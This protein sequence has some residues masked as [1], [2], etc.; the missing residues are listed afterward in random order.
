MAKEK[1]II[2]LEV[3]STKAVKGLKE[4][5]K[6]MEGVGKS[7]TAVSKGFKGVAVSMKAMGWGILVGLLAMV[8]EAFKRNQ[9]VSDLVARGMDALQKVVNV[10]VKVFQGALIVADALTF[11]LLNLSGA[12]DQ[13]S[14]SLQNQ[15]NEV[16][17]LQAQEQLIQLEFQKSAEV[18]RQ[19]RDDESKSI[20][21]RKSANQELGKILDEQH[22]VEMKNANRALEVSKNELAANSNSIELQE[23]VI[24]AKTKVAEVDERIT[25][26]RSEMLVNVNSLNRANQELS[27]TTGGVSTSVKEA[28]KSYEDLNKEMKTALGLD[29]TVESITKRIADA[30]KV[31]KEEIEKETEELEELIDSEKKYRNSS[32]KT[33]EELKDKEK[34]L[35]DE[36][37]SNIFSFYEYDFNLSAKENE[38]KLEERHQKRMRA[39]D[40]LDLLREQIKEEEKRL[41]SS[42][43]S[44]KIRVTKHNEEL[45]KKV[46]EH[47][48]KMI[49]SEIEFN[50]KIK[51]ARQMAR[52]E[53]SYLM[54]TDQDRELTDLK[55]EKD[56][57]MLMLEDD[58]ASQLK[59]QYWYAQEVLNIKQ[60]FRI[61]EVKLAEEEAQEL[62]DIETQRIEKAFSIASSFAAS[63][64]KFAGDNVKAQKSAAMLGITIDTAAAVSS[65]IRNAIPQGGG[66]PVLTP[67]IIA[68][69]LAIVFGG[70]AQ[71]KG[72]L[73]TVPGGSD[74]GTPDLQGLQAGIGVGDVPRLPGDNNIDMD[75]PPVQA[76]V[77]ESNVTSKQALQNDLE[78]QATL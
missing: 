76:F 36:R 19:I 59:L 78:I 9:A 8:F 16:R 45:V 52:D 35:T 54:G 11:G 3:Q 38:R 56:K 66:N 67:L 65:V 50:N 4:T 5:S 30:H 6:A 48:Q 27:K 57:H 44:R 21:E 71:A 28:V 17:L 29:K 25:S 74:G 42:N 77:V 12:S 39:L 22:T 31:R 26:Q 62:I 61:E 70:M 37:R 60:K 73:A 64:G 34:K 32:V 53:L 24:Q 40:E 46:A 68:E 20:E 10:V 72:I 69:L 33:L 23:K 75:L 55:K 49:D 43:A 1:K 58:L 63:M 15:R 47:K 18:Q 7:S 13:A 2:E 51:A 14:R 41:K